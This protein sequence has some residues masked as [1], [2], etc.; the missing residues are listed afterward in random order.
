MLKSDFYFE[1]PPDL[2]AQVPLEKRTDSRLLVM[3]SGRPLKD[4][5]FQ[6]LPQLLR[7]GD[8]LVLNDTRVIPARVFGAKAT[9][10]RIEILLERL[11]DPYTALVH[12]RASKSP[13]PGARLLLDGG[14]GCEVI[15]R[16]ES[17]FVL[18]FD[19]ASPVMSVLEAVGHIPLPPYI[20]RADTLT[21]RERYQTVFSAL[22]LIHI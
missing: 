17:L 19:Q 13:K 9:G 4:Q 8:L 2:I 11:L 1:L 20:G 7:S 12:L 15:E 22:S 3:E 10:G 14:Y 18:R 16:R 6:E 21:D 5:R